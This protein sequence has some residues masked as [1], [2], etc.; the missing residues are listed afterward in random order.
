M[1]TNKQAS[2]HKRALPEKLDRRVQRTRQLLRDALM[3]LILERGY[4]AVTVEAVAERANLGRAT[5]YLHYRDKEELL[6]TS[7]KDIY[8]SL[9]QKL[10]AM[11]SELRSIVIFEHAAEH[12]DL[13]RVMLSGQG[14]SALARSVR[15][16]MVDA[17]QRQMGLQFPMLGS[18]TPIPVEIL[19][20]HIAGS[21]LALIT[22]WLENNLPHSPETMARYFRL[23]NVESLMAFFRPQMIQGN[24]R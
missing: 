2:T 10:Q 14:A 7:L 9:V 11:Q 3:G 1:S 5:F 20:N 8:D 22:W 4:D 24:G 12:K 18:Q 6:V 17:F 21:L 23:L 13:Y 15:E 16:Y 19:A